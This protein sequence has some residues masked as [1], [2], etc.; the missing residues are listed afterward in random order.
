MARHPQVLPEGSTLGGLTL[1]RVLGRGASAVV[2]EARDARGRPVAV[3][4]REPGEPALDRRFLRE[5]ESLRRLDL[6]GVV[7]VFEAGIDPR[8]IW[9]SMER[10]KGMTIRRWIQAG[11]DLD[12]RIDR[13]VTIGARLARSLAG[14]HQHGFVHRDLKPSNVMVNE[15]GEV[16]LLDFG[17]VQW[18]A[19]GESLTGTGGL[20]GTPSFMA[21]EQV[22]GL[23]LTSAADVYA[24]AL[25]L[26]EGILGRRPR[27]PTPHGWLVVQCLERVAPMVCREP[28][29]PR[30]LS[31]LI[32][33]CL[34]LDPFDRPSA[35]EL[36][37][38]L[39][40]LPRGEAPAEWPES[41]LFVGRQVELSALE[42]ATEGQG[43]RIRVLAG[44]AGSGRRRL[45][46]QLRRRALLRGIRSERASCR[47]EAPGGAVGEW[48][49]KLLSSPDREEWR[50]QIA[51]EDASTLL[52]MW[53]E[54]PLHPLSE[55]Q[56]QPRAAS[57]KEVVRA[58]A[59]T[60]LRACKEFPLVFE[61]RD[62][63][64]LDSIT[65]RVLAHL[66][67]APSRSLTVI[68]V[69]DPRWLRPRTERLLR[70]LDQQLELIELSP[71]DPGS[72]QILANSLVP[73][74][75]TVVAGAGTPLEAATAGLA[76]LARLRGE[77]FREIGS[78][79]A[80]L[81][82]LRNPLPRAVLEAYALPPEDLAEGGFVVRREGLWRIAGES[83]R[84]AALARLHNRAEAHDRLAQ[85]WEA[86]GRGPARWLHI[87]E[88]RVRGRGS[89][90][91][92]GAAV[93]AALAAERLGRLR[94]ARSWLLLLDG[95][96]HD[97][98]SAIY[99]QLRFPLAWCRARVA[100]LTDT[101]RPRP[102]LVEAAASRVVSETDAA[103]QAQLEAELLLRQGMTQAAREHAERA[104]ETHRDACPL[105]AR[106][107]LGIAGSAELDLGH[108]EAALQR[109]LQAED[110]LNDVTSTDPVAP[111]QLTEL[112]A[113]ALV[114]S[115]AL[116]A[117][118]DAARRGLGE[119]QALGLRG[120]EAKLLQTLATAQ[121][122]LGDR[123]EAEQAARR[124]YALFEANADRGGLA[125][126]AVQLAA[127]AAGRGEAA[128]T[129][130]HLDEALATARKLQLQRLLPM[131]AAVQLELA[132]LEDDLLLSQ[133][134]FEHYGQLRLQTHTWDLAEVR[135]F[136]TRG[137]RHEVEK[138]VAASPHRAGYQAALAQLELGRV[139]LSD[140][141]LK[142]SARAVKLGH[143]L[144]QRE[145][146]RELTL[147]A[148][149]LAGVIG[150]RQARSWEKLVSTC[151]RA[152]WA[153]LFLGALEFDGRRH[154][155]LGDE[156]AAR[157]RF[158][159]LHTRSVDLGHRPYVRAAQRLLHASGR[160]TGR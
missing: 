90:D 106:E 142:A 54:L 11:G 156:T 152:R 40:A 73:D 145:G 114:A 159:T 153:E 37:E 91:I 89:S 76:T 124:A 50:A 133:Q 46:E 32:D 55:P 31:T 42:A 66:G 64:E 63:E 41:P 149:L 38:M 3:K 87:A 12:S 154:R 69:L 129:R 108:P 105:E 158:R 127:L 130:K 131:A 79:E 5:F 128:A 39:E 81:G 59:D 96:D 65:A 116:A 136:R 139:R 1:G 110:L 68:C 15:D 99:R 74:G 137:K 34:A 51:G 120:V 18:W 29:V 8:A 80:S 141:D 70:R 78:V 140:G 53:P 112:R 82:I 123:S 48:L 2:Y 26:Y 150:P 14:V 10:V 98:S 103:M 125:S 119:A 62:L 35:A 57:R 97:R 16:R 20:V 93:Q 23:A 71:L 60:I 86:R 84:T 126:A 25:M 9:F 160:P 134:A 30:A 67:Q 83:F 56:E 6:P 52:Q 58:A 88:H 36:A 100:Q 85:A 135:W 147:Y 115:G 144:A 118:T 117:G 111:L 121:M 77:P 7:R 151:L 143:T 94:E 33:R 4:L 109:A 21:P 13:A 101:E 43:P 19:V 157:R 45:V 95:L 132:T 61:L 138:L 113:G 122:R 104:A 22:A 146:L 49:S 47:M 24:C 28:E 107:L 75:T 17:V 44:P 155:A 92:W 102:D 27:P 72:A 148:R